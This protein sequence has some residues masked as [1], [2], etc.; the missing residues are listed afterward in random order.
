MLFTLCKTRAK[1]RCSKCCYDEEERCL[2]ETWT[3]MELKKAL[4]FGY[5]IKEIYE[6]YDYK[7]KGKIF[8]DYVNAFLKIKQ[9]SSG[10]PANCCVKE[11]VVD[12][13]INAYLDHEG[14][15]LDWKKIIRNEGMRTVAKT[16][17]NSLWGKF[18]QNEGNTKVVFV[19]DYDELMEWVQDKRYDLTTFDFVSEDSMRLCLHPKEAYITPLKNGNV[20]VACFVTSYSRL[21]LLEKSNELQHRV[22]YSD[23]DSIIYCV[24]NKEKKVKMWEFFR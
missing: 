1:I 14:I 9:V 18:A 17:L 10:F 7:K 4:E 16:L 11:S 13:Y 6:I 8:Q 24:K 21:C 19:K 15:S 12:E 2:Q 3:S 22:L 23:M 5:V 20:I